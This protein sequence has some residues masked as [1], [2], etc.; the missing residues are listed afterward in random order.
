MPFG[1]ASQLPTNLSEYMKLGRAQKPGPSTGNI[2][3][4]TFA[5]PTVATSAGTQVRAVTYLPGGDYH[6]LA[7]TW[8]TRAFTGTPDMLV[9][10]APTA[11]GAAGVQIVGFTTTFSATPSGIY[12]SSDLGNPRV[13]GDINPYMR[14]ELGM[15]SSTLTDLAVSIFYYRQGHLNPD[16]VDD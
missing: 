2:E 16:P 8:N 14:I 6:I 4:F 5:V 9:S 10:A 1:I 11:Q 3:C 13:S 12:Y 7:I 15:A